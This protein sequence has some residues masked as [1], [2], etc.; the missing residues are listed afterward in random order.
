MHKNFVIAKDTSAQPLRG[1]RIRRYGKALSNIGLLFALFYVPAS[2]ADCTSQA[3]GNWNVASTWVCTT[4]GAT[5]T[6]TDNVTVTG[7]HTVDV[8]AAATAL[9]L[10]ISGTGNSTLRINPGI[11]LNVSGLTTVSNATTNTTKSLQ[12]LANATDGGRISIGGNLNLTGSGGSKA[13]AFL[14]GNHA[15]T[16]ATVSGNITINNPATITFNGAGTFNVGGNF[17]SGASFTAGTGT[18]IYNGTAAQSIGAYT[19]YNLTTNNPNA[20]ATLVNNT[21]V[22]ANLTVVPA[23]GTLDT[24]NRTLDIGGNLLVNGTLNG[25]NPITL[26]GVN[27]TIDGSGFVNSTGRL[28]ITLGNKSILATANL[29]FAGEIRINGAFIV[30]NN[31]TITSTSANGITGSANNSTWENASGST[32]NIA[33]AL[34]AT[35]TLKADANPNT[36]NYNGGANQT[37]KL[38]TPPTYHH[39]SLSGASTKTLPN[40]AL[41]IAGNLSMSGTAL[42][43]TQAALTL[44]GNFDIAPTAAFKANNFS[45]S[46]QGNFTNNSGINFNAGTSTFTLN[47]VLAQSITGISTFNNLVIANT[48]AAVTA[49]SALTLNGNFTTN[50]GAIFNAGSATHTLKG[51]FTNSG[52]FNAGAGTVVFGGTAAQTLNGATTFNHLT[53]NNPADL[54]INNDVTVGGTHTFTNGNIITGALNTLVIASTGSVLRASGHVIGNL[55]KY[56]SAAALSKVFEVGDSANYTPVDINFNSVSNPGHLT[57]STTASDHP[58]L[59]TSAIDSGLSINRYWTVTKDANLSFSSYGI[60]F[61]Y[62]NNGNAVDLD[63]NIN[64]ATVGATTYLPDVIMQ[65]YNGSTWSNITLNGL[66]LDIQASGSGVTSFSDFAMGEP[67]NKNFEREVQFIYTRELY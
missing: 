34:L 23:T 55:R 22:S 5:P 19:Y 36:V 32:L 49:N 45:H 12:L 35:G 27:T 53:V 21:V 29:T 4:A 57:A 37:I 26:S 10:T 9:S 13:V 6:A 14:L 25:T 15:N 39:L 8:T 54:T 47:G 60:V 65:K 50:T 20:T 40:S 3:S 43:D 58:Q 56:F 17:Q 51:N 31:G 38:P 18:V 24:S 48:A 52:T 16:R 62:V 33:D 41:T 11:T 63:V 67:K 64:T 66:P 28:D 61:H 7:G 30:T 44:N 1:V 46:L 2:F 42:G 59:S